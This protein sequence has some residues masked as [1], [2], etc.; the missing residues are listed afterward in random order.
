MITW[1]RDRLVLSVGF[2]GVCWP[3]FVFYK[4][5]FMMKV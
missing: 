3:I 2:L 5:F 1:P 4:D